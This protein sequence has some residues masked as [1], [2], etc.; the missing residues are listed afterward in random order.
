MFG[1][2]IQRPERTLGTE[3]RG[4]R[5]IIQP[6]GQ[7][8]VTGTELEKSGLQ[9]ALPRNQEWTWGRRRKGAVRHFNIFLDAYNQHALF[10]DLRTN[11]ILISWMKRHRQSWKS[12]RTVKTRWKAVPRRKPRL[13]MAWL[14]TWGDI[15]SFRRRTTLDDHPRIRGMLPISFR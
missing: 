4:D 6:I 3:S 12:E 7:R 15:S 2:R 1:W 9:I 14:I 10:A 5:Q 13:W 11:P 8:R